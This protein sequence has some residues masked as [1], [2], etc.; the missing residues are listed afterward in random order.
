MNVALG[1]H[2]TS[3]LQA[4]LE[5]CQTV[6]QDGCFQAI[7]G[8][9]Q[10]APVDTDRNEYLSDWVTMPDAMASI[11]VDLNGL[12]LSI[13]S[14]LIASW[15]HQSGKRTVMPCMYLPDNMGTTAGEISAAT[16]T[17][18]A[19]GTAVATLTI[20]QPTTEPE[21]YLNAT[22]CFPFIFLAGIWNTDG[23]NHHS[24]SLQVDGK[25]LVITLQE[26][27][28]TGLATFLDRM[29]AC[30]E[31]KDF[32][33]EHGIDSGDG[34]SVGGALCS[35]L[36]FVRNSAVGGSFHEIAQ[37]VGKGPAI[38]LQ[39]TD[40]PVYDALTKVLELTKPM[41]VYLFPP[42]ESSKRAVGSDPAKSAESFGAVAFSLA[43]VFLAKHQSLDGKVSL[44]L[45]ELKWDGQS[46]GEDNSGDDEDGEDGED[47]DDDDSS[48]D[49]AADD[50][51][52]DGEGGSGDCPPKETVC[53]AN[54]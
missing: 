26:D 3:G 34:R 19:D 23:M 33:T 46:G 37:I 1:S 48:G 16:A 29:F 20:V 8:E 11:F 51:D 47:D 25:E 2:V 49:D 28:W 44:E 40:S 52:D 41:A 15:K 9:L 10:K 5:G 42:E 18:S 43:Y 13:A 22:P 4:I 45:N 21:R 35:A 27:L 30:R 24:G 14:V 50:G 54:K 12:H 32:D 6:D 31:G 17:L 7:I 38:T 36:A 39:Q 53:T